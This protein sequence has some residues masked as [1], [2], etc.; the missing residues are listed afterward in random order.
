MWYCDMKN[1][2]DWSFKKEKINSKGFIPPKV[3]EGE[4]WW[5]SIGINIGEEIDGKGENYRRPCVIYKKINNKRFLVIPGTSTERVGDMYFS[6]NFSDQVGYFCLN[7]IRVID[8]KRLDKKHKDSLVLDHLKMKE[9][10]EQILSFLDIK[11]IPPPEA[12]GT[13]DDTAPHINNIIA[14]TDY[15]SSI[16]IDTC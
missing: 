2:K 4:V 7:Q 6:I 12:G 9:I 3:E 5:V 15:K 1:F 8:Y 13:E 14:D 11:L 10:K 16:K